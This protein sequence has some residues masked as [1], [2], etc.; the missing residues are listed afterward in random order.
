MIIETKRKTLSSVPVN[1]KEI[2]R[3][4]GAKTVYPELSALIE[5]CLRECERENAVN[6]AAVY[7]ELPLA[8]SGDT[9][10]FSVFKFT[11][12]DLVKALRGAKSA[13]VFACTLGMGIDRLIKKYSETEP[14]RALIFQAI[15]A[16]RVESFT[17][18]FLREY[19]INN[20]VKLSARFSAGYGD[21]PLTAQ[22]D[23]FALLKPQKEIGLTL[24]DSLLISPSKSVTAIVGV[25]G[26]GCGKDGCSDCGKTD[27]GY[28][29]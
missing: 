14:A 29:R 11:S 24:N 7:A 27:C 15:G 2:I 21:L 4:A 6:Y 23:I 1:E 3:Y 13:L 25:N 19:A 16:E 9:A 22:K 28:R 26:D 5:R 8:V 18:E 20:G 12:K 17:D 10:D